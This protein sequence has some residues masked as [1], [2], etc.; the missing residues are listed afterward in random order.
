MKV[1]VKC[2][3]GSHLF[4]TN[5]EKSDKDF[6]GVFIPSAH[7]ILIGNYDDT[8]VIKTNL[9]NTRNTAED[10]DIELYSLRKF[11]K[12]CE[13]G[14]TAALELLFTPPSCI[15]QQSEEWGEIL[16]MR[17][18][19]LCKSVKAIIGYS[20]QQAAKY[21]A[22]GSR[23]GELS[24]LNDMLKE[25][26]KTQGADKI[27][28]V[29][30]DLKEFCKTK[31]HIVVIKMQNPAKGVDEIDGISILGSKFDHHTTVADLSKWTSNKFKEYGQRAREAKNNNGID[32]KALS[33]GLR[34]CIQAEELLTTGKITLPHT[35]DNLKL[36]MDVKLGKYDFSKIDELLDSKLARVEELSKS[37]HLPEKIDP[38]V[39]RFTLVWFHKKAVDNMNEY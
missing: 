31:N 3:A 17:D 12:M 33:H 13:N 8:K 27:K 16:E 25:L 18:K 4:G 26:S 21:G 9:T 32:W 6:K 34:V 30:E 15:I 5:T 7:D 10:T 14:D 29:F 39:T 37:S 24:Q 22:K 35:G 28:N 1:I 2:V 20:R 38:L 23:L 36:L 11:L 19:L